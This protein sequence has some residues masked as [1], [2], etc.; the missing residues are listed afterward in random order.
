LPSHY[1]GFGLVITESLA[2]GTPVI[3]SKN[4]G[5]SEL[6]ESLQSRGK[7]F[8]VVL[9]DQSPEEIARSIRMASESL[10]IRDS[11]FLLNQGLTPA[12]HV[13]SIL[14]RYAIA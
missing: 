12:Q 10:F 9:K 14:K 2:C 5:A 4:A 8:G 11:D 7:N 1:D 13:D 6:I 3:V